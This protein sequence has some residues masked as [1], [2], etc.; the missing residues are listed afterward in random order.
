ML[1]N[2]NVTRRA[3]LRGLMAYGVAPFSLAI[4]R[5]PDLLRFGT[6][7]VFLNDRVETTRRWQQY[8]ETATG[9]RVQF[10]QRGSYGEILELLM[11]DELD[12]A[13]V[14]GYPYVMA[15][16]RLT[17][18]A[19]P[20]YHG[21]PLYQS[22]VIVPE[23]DRATQTI[24]DLAGKIYAF[25]DPLS[26]SGYLVPRIEL[27]S[28]GTSPDRFFKKTFFTFSHRKVVDAVRLGLANG[29][30]VDGYVW[31]TL[32]AQQPEAVQGVR[33]A[34]RSKEFGFPPLVVRKSL[35]GED[36]TM[37]KDAFITM[38]RSEGGRD[39]LG[40]LNLDGFANEPDSIFDTIAQM[41]HTANTSR[42]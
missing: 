25:S 2:R 22:Y 12:V 20:L 14:C 38:G 8:L 27:L 40:R 6:T 19:T 17:L 10:V 32:A 33:V 24:G 5:D 28:R 29:G 42:T 26:N 9:K 16:D 31:D 3:V 11:R 18:L 23:S 41:A 36:A 35:A 30:S 39:V 37:L 21:K 4:G 13:W 15:K 34:W 7:P 1:R